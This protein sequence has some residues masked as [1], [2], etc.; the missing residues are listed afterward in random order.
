MPPERSEAIL[1]APPTFRPVSVVSSPVRE[2]GQVQ[3]RRESRQDTRVEL[4]EVGQVVDRV[5]QEEVL[6]AIS[7]QPR[8]GQR[9][10]HLTMSS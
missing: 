6:R 9:L 10:R 5:H 7:M 4:G 2:S 8:Q 3:D 1:P